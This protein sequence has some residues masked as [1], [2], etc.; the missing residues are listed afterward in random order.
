MVSLDRST[1]STVLLTFLVIASTGLVA[2]TIN[3]VALVDTDGSSPG[4]RDGPPPAGEGERINIDVSQEGSSGGGESSS[5]DAVVCI[6]LLQSPIAILGI[7]AG[8]FGVIYGIYRRYNTATAGLFS[9]GIIPMVMLTYFLLTNCPQRG[10]TGGGAGVFNGAAALNNSGPMLSPPPIPPTAIALLFGGVMVV[11]VVLLF[12]SM[13]DEEEF[14]PIEEDPEDLET[15]DF[16]RAAGRAA[17]RIE[18]TNVAVDNAVYRAWLE[19]TG[20]LDI[21]NPD[22]TAP[23]DF[24]EAAIEAGL[25]E[26]DVTELAELFTE[27]RYGGKSA[28]TREDRAIEVLRNIERTYEDSVDQSRDDE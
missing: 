9:T 22:T 11:A 17:D 28:E 10:G 18:E 5:I 12:T 25:D 14:E 27:V 6:R 4:P 15:A 26:D 16:A 20:L 8:V 7:V 3:S 13:G 21:E 23:R 2:A 1:A 24:A 19:M